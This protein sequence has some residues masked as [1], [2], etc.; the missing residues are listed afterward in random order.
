MR[1]YGVP[2]LEAFLLKDTLENINGS[3]VWLVR[4]GILFGWLPLETN[5]GHD[6]GICHNSRQNLGQSSDEEDQ[7]RGHVLALKCLQYDFLDARVHAVGDSGVDDQDQRGLQSLPKSCPALLVNNLLGCRHKILTLTEGHGLLAGGDDSN[8]N[9]KNLSQCTCSS[10]DQQFHDGRD[11][12]SCG[13]PVDITGS[14]EG[15]PVKISKVLRRRAEKSRKQT[16]IETRETLG[17]EDLLHSISGGEVYI[18]VGSIG[19]GSRPNLHAGFDTIMF[20]REGRCVLL[21]MDVVG[22]GKKEYKEG[23]EPIDPT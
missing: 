19:S 12:D 9:G 7:S 4:L 10:A 15:V 13:L 18:G 23:R 17:L 3:G 21:G 1:T 2:A 8:G 16:C 11:G 20:L 6:V 14:D 22:S 5:L